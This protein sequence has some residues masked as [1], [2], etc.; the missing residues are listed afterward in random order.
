MLGT[1]CVQ[2]LFSIMIH[3]LLPQGSTLVWPFMLYSLS[4]SN[5]LDVNDISIK[6]LKNTNSFILVKSQNCS[7]CIAVINS[8]CSIKHQLLF[9]STWQH[10]QAEVERKLK[11]GSAAGWKTHV[12]GVGL[13]GESQ[14]VCWKVGWGQHGS[15]GLPGCE[16]CRGERMLRVDAKCLG[17]HTEKIPYLSMKPA[18]I[19]GWALKLVLRRA[20]STGVQQGK[21]W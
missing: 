11:A 10:P 6:Q 13:W 20:S 14:C 5:L 2:V 15:C 18:R 1:P 3:L 9:G 21:H 19:Q 8:G 17:S 12:F 7:W 16:K 4:I